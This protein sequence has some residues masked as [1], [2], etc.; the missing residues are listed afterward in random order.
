MRNKKWPITAAILALM[1]I[2]AFVAGAIARRGANDDAH[3]AADAV[4]RWY[5]RHGGAQVRS[6]EA[7]ADSAPNAPIYACQ[8]VA[9][10]C[11]HRALFAIPVVNDQIDV[12]G[13]AA[14]LGPP[15]PKRC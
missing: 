12:H 15:K 3:R 13:V 8:F 11:V 6:C 14:P 4:Q 2:G 5:L 1:V 9:G 7:A 10:G